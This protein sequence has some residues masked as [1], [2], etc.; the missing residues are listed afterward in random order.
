MKVSP[1]VN[2]VLSSQEIDVSDKQQ[3]LQEKRRK[4][5]QGVVPLNLFIVCTISLLILSGCIFVWVSSF[6]VTSNS[7]EN[8]NAMFI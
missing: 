1:E 5:Y 6:I 8:L 2:T 4:F 7:I 3:L